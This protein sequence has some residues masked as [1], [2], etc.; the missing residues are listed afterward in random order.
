[1]E[2]ILV[3]AV[4]FSLC[5]LVDRGFARIF[6][7]RSQHS[8]GLSVRLSKRYGSI[9]LILVVVG[10][11]AVF[12]GMADT[13][14]LSAGG[15][16]LILV[17]VGLVTY[18]MTFGIYYDEDSF[19]LTTF[20]KRSTTYRFSQ[21]RA[22]QLYNSYGSI[23]IELHMGDGRTVQLQD[24]MTGLYPFLD[25]AFRQWCSQ[26]GKDPADCPFHDPDNSCWFP[27]VEV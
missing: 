17:G 26:R 21:I 6:R 1:M 2:M 19:V 7:G 25:H 16:L 23:V 15:G 5:Y 12:A 27:P 9:G 8:S 3:V 18:Y 10:I 20:G 4:T 11:A 24:S 13:W 22:Q 14:V